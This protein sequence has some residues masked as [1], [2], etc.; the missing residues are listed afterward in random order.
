M[1]RGEIGNESKY[2]GSAVS[3]RAGAMA[4]VCILSNAMLC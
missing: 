2:F 1:D 3:G 4:A